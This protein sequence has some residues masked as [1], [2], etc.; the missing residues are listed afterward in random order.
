ML[1]VSREDKLCSTFTQQLNTCVIKPLEKSL[2][3]PS[4][5]KK[6]SQNNKSTSFHEST[7]INQEIECVCFGRKET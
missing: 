2:T 3:C 4:R 7:A 6:M 5:G 1:I